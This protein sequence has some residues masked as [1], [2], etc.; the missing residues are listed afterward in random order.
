M[1]PPI[2]W[3]KIEKQIAQ[4]QKAPT[5]SKKSGGESWVF[6]WYLCGSDLESNGGCASQ[7]LEELMS[8]DLPENVTVVFEA[9]GASAWHNDFDPDV[10][11]R[12]IY[13]SDGLQIVEE[14]PSANMGDPN[15][16]TD[17]LDFC[18]TNYP[19]DRRAVFSGIMAV[20]AYPV[21][22]LTSFTIMILFGY[23]S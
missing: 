19:A 9:G 1:V 6:Y 3:Q 10:L 12:G 5:Q 23:R 8:V 13:N 20:E 21:Q 17:F 16:L 7:D 15:T 11:T 4:T 2:L 14:I 18:N 22:P